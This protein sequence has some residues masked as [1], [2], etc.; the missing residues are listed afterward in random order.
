MKSKNL[1]LI[2]IVEAV[3]LVCLCL[4]GAV[5][6]FYYLGGQA[7]TA[8]GSQPPAQ[9]VIEATATLFPAVVETPTETPTPGPGGTLLEQLP[10]GMVKFVDYDAG[11]EL[12]VPNG[13]LGVR[14]SDP[15][16]FDAVLNGEATRNENLRS[17]VLAD[18]DSV[19]TDD[20]LYMYVLRPDLL[21]DVVFGF[22]QTVWDSDDTQVLDNATMGT[23]V[24]GL[25]TDGDFPGFKVVASNIDKNQNKVSI[26]SIRGRFTITYDDGSSLPVVGTVIF[27]KPTPDSIVRIVFTVV[28]EF[29]PEIAPDVEAVIQSIKLLGR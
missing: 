22:S 15:A 9:P 11:F 23:L 14:P 10:D 16:E 18:R 1:K 20:R 3:L 27:F 21:K 12:V 6:V 2:V 25:E 5:G 4:G 7:L 26:M 28:K 8:G 29:D 17:Q 13:W 24:R 19:E